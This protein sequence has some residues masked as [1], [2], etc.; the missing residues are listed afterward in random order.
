MIDAITVMCCR[1]QIEGDNL[2]GHSRQALNYAFVAGGGVIM[3]E[4]R[5]AV[6]RFLPDSTHG[7]CSWANGGRGA[8]GG[9]GGGAGGAGGSG[10]TGGAAGGWGRAG[11]WG[12]SGAGSASGGGGGWK[13]IL[14][15]GPPALPT[16]VVKDMMP[17]CAI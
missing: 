10:G 9:A 17:S 11:G 13:H 7:P 16:C 5:I 4:G 8:V 15:P 1:R 3:V 12:G 14:N 2:H 6:A